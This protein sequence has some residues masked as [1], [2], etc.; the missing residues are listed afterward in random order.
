MLVFPET[1]RGK[2]ALPGHSHTAPWHWFWAQRQR[3]VEDSA[4][5]FSTDPCT[6]AEAVRSTELTEE[7]RPAPSH[8][9]QAA[10]EGGFC[11]FIKEHWNL[12]TSVLEREEGIQNL[13]RW[14]PPPHA[15]PC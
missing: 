9:P 5:S 10:E 7:L 15:P 11:F 6:H 2:G 12:N 3:E 14:H 8:E 1:S 4:R 13:Q